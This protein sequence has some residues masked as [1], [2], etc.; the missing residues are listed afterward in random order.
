MGLYFWKSRR[1]VNCLIIKSAVQR[2]IRTA[3]VTDF[4]RPCPDLWALVARR[5]SA[6]LRS[7]NGEG[8]V[9]RIWSNLHAVVEGRDLELQLGL[10]LFTSACVLRCE[11]EDAHVPQMNKEGTWSSSTA[12]N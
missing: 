11:G 12:R 9:E 8:I 1:N 3:S 7:I 5:V 10:G 6:A 2:A 4:L